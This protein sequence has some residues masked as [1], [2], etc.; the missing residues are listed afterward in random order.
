MTSPPPIALRRNYRSNLILTKRLF[1]FSLWWFA[2]VISFLN[3]HVS[4]ELEETFLTFQLGSSHC[5]P[6]PQFHLQF[7]RFLFL[8]CLYVNGLPWW[9]T[10][11]S[12]I[13]L[14]CRRCGWIPGLGRTLEEE[15]ATHS[16]ILAWEIPRTEEPGGLQFVGSQRAGHD[17]AHT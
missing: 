4:P 10:Q 3:F 8:L 7:S 15:M 9:L 1:I 13:H 11:W 2:A 5:F 14:P 16:S 12:R 6:H 17:R